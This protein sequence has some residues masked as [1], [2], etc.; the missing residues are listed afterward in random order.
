[1]KKLLSLF[2][3][4]LVL[5]SFAGCGNESNNQTNQSQN[6]SSSAK[7][8]NLSD[9]LAEIKEQ[10]TF[11]SMAVYSD[12]EDLLDIYGI[13]AEYV[14]QFVAEVNDSGLEQDEIV[15]IEA[16]DAEAAAKIQERLQKRYDSK[17]S[18]NENYNPE[19]AEIIKACKVEVN[20]NFVS[21]IV[22]PD[23]EKITNIYKS[24]IL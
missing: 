22:S 14:K 19:Q 11:P 23:A 10:V 9:V 4:V 12:I 7:E 13:K 21:L 8:V 16:V 2:I 17:L 5:A 18:Q 20:G 24:N 3:A 1:M 15:I 6:A